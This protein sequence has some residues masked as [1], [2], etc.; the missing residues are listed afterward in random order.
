MSENKW[1]T[2]W[3]PGAALI[4]GTLLAGGIGALLGGGFSDYESLTAPPLAPPGWL[5][6]VVWTVLYAAM[7][8]AAFLVWRTKDGDRA[9]ALKLYGAQLLVNILWP[10]FYFRL[11]W[12]LF[13]FFWLLLLILLAMLTHRSFQRLEE[14]AGL[15]FVPYLV[16]L[17]F[18]AYLNLGYYILNP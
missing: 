15:L 8:I 10:L 2:F 17:A 12:R 7:G 5:F 16:W 6:P 4:G 11:E 3:I 14:R 1:K 18:A 9:D 13:A